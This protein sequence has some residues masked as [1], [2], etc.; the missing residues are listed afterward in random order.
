M[1]RARAVAFIATSLDGFIARPDGAIDWLEQQNARLPAGEDCGYA[2]FFVGIDALL[3]GRKTFELVQGF[4][5]WPYG[6]KPVIVLS[7]GGVAVPERLRATVS[8]TAEPP[9]ALLQRL[10]R[11][12]VQRVYVDGG[13]TL[14]SFL[15]EGLLDEITVTTVPVLLGRGRPL[16]GALAGDVALELVASRHWDFGFVQNRWRVLRAA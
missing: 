15:C 5:P 7:R 3:M 13:L 12:E 4:D 11:E 16:F 2:A 9:L 10:G 6:D 8:T 14:Q 1:S